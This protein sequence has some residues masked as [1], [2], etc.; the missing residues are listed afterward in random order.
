[1]TDFTIPNSASMF[2]PTQREKFDQLDNDLR[3]RGKGTTRVDFAKSDDETRFVQD[4]QSPA[5]QYPRLPETS[6]WSQQQPGLEP[7]LG[8]DNEMGS[9][10]FP[11]ALGEQFEIERSAEILA[12]RQARAEGS[13]DPS[14]VSPTP[15]TSPGVSVLPG[16]SGPD[17]SNLPG[18]RADGM[19][20]PNPLGLAAPIPQT[21]H[22]ALRRIFARRV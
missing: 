12:N 6:P 20:A 16:D 18:A 19:P 9:P 2:T 13:V 14:E 8:A 10:V 3:K 22:D 5:E 11:I 1:M 21:A 7:P 17:P 4:T 15:T